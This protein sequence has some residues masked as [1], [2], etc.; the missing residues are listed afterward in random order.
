M[1][2]ELAL[3]S[4][5]RN[6]SLMELVK[7]KSKLY[8]RLLELSNRIKQFNCPKRKEITNPEL[9]LEIMNKKRRTCN[10][11]YNKLVEKVNLEKSNQ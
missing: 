3:D 5:S 6:L 8:K 1:M 11:S 4:N 7:Q 2:V 10:E 9:Y